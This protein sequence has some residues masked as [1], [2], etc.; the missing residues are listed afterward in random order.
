MH[1]LRLQFGDLAL[2]GRDQRIAAAIEAPQDPLDRGLEEA[3][4]IIARVGLE[5]RVDRC[6][7]RQI[8]LAR[9]FERPMCHRIGRGQ[10]QHIGCE[11]RQVRAHLGVDPQ[12]QAIFAAALHRHAGIGH[13]DEIARRREV[14]FGHHRGIDAQRRAL[15]QQIVSQPVER[16]VGPVAGIIVVPAEKRDA[17]IGHI[18]CARL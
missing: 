10:M 6:Q 15:A 12:G 7:H 5:P 4:P 18:H 2:R 14:G 3:E 8:A 16:L 1:L 9:P 13:I 17:E 11:F